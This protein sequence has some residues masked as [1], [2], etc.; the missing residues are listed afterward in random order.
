MN[1]PTLIVL[2]KQEHFETILEE[3]KGGF[4]L[5]TSWIL[6]HSYV[7]IKLC[8]V[9]TFKWKYWKCYFSNSHLNFKHLLMNNV[10]II[11]NLHYTF[12]FHSNWSSERGVNSQCDDCYYSWTS[13]VVTQSSS[14][15]L[16]NEN[17]HWSMLLEMMEMSRIIE[18]IKRE[19]ERREDH[20]ILP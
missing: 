6:T 5:L 20:R 8:F 15:K 19:R 17:G 9:L 2:D 13:K 4:K 1:P 12:I 18:N 3:R 14:L 7:P 10:S 16:A 11:N